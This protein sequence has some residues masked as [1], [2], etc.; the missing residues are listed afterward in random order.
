PVRPARRD[1]LPGLDRLR[2][3]AK[4]RYRCRARL[5]Q[6][7]RHRLTLN[8]DRRRPANTPARGRRSRGLKDGKMRI[9]ITGGCGFF[10]RRVAIRLLER[11]S[12][13]GPGDELVLFDNAAPALA[14]PEDKRAR[15]V[16]GDIA[17]RESGGGAVAPRPR[18][19]L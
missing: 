1:R 7:L 5:G 3:P 15:V 13:R 12:A 10:G 18:S 8:K 11:G 17:H 9:V 2:V 6:A 4:G 14:P 19:S 16:N